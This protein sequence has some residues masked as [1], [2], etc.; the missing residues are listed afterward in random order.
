MMSSVLQE[1]PDVI[2]IVTKT[3]WGRA[4][5]IQAAAT[6]LIGL[7]LHLPR[8]FRSS[9]WIIAATSSLALAATSGLS[10]HAFAAPA[11]TSLSIAT[12][13]AHVIGAAGWLGSLVFVWAVGVPALVASANDERWKNVASLVNTFSPVALTFAAIVLLTGVVSAGLRLGSVSALWESAYG[14]RLLV[15]L[16]VLGGAGDRRFRRD[17]D[18]RV[19][20]LA[21]YEKLDGKWRIVH[22]HVSR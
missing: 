4:W 15:K 20:S 19:G 11:W 9:G 22:L 21:I 3:N 2:G 13:A 8:R 12:D 6:I 10:G 5:V 16:A 18:G 1:E 7:C 14:R 17:C